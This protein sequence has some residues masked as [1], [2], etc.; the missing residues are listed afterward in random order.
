M[1]TFAQ[2]MRRDSA[3]LAKSQPIDPLAK[4]PAGAS[5][6]DYAYVPD[7][8]SPSTWKLNISDAGHVGGAIA[9]L[10]PGFRGRK[11]QIPA[12]ARARVVGRVR[13]AW[14]RF[15]PG[16]TP[17]TILKAEVAK[18][19][20]QSDPHL[21][22][23][24][25]PR[26]GKQKM[27]EAKRIGAQMGVDGVDDWQARDTARNLVQRGHIKPEHHKAMLAAFGRNKIDLNKAM[28]FSQSLA[29]YNHNHGRNGEFAS[30]AGGAGAPPVKGP[31]G[32]Q[33][34]TPSERDKLKEKGLWRDHAT[35]HSRLKNAIKQKHLIGADVATN[36]RRLAEAKDHLNT[37]AK[38]RGTEY[39]SRALNGA[40]AKIDAVNTHIARGRAW[41]GSGK[42][43]DER[44]RLNSGLSK[45]FAA[46]L[47][48]AELEAGHLGPALTAVS[49]HFR[50]ALA[51]AKASGSSAWN[52]GDGEVYDGG[53][54]EGDGPES[55]TPAA[56][57]LG[58]RAPGAKK[59]KVAKGERSDYEIEFSF[60]VKKADAAQQM[61]YGWANVSKLDGVEVTDREGDF[62]S[63]DELRKAAHDFI[64]K[65]REGDERHGPEVTGYIVE[66]IIVDDDIKKALGMDVP[67]E[68]WFIGYK[69]TND[70]VWKR[71]E[72]GEYKAFSI[73]GT[74]VRVPEAVTA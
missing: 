36:Q 61:I 68:G 34:Q 57:E 39:H 6:D 50:D 38:M 54:G 16:E 17:P 28:T 66:S 64:L 73:G 49:V 40:R 23:R 48:K 10:G 71:V 19:D 31:W 32:A 2:A 11:A 44:A 55:L 72:K 12:A 74:A 56:E 13:A 25:M 46:A 15:H 4:A 24:Y 8:K 52:D 69:V 5:A 42:P 41:R 37:A 67:Q 51:K 26:Q 53:L 43:F 63:I 59:K 7:P 9:A 22:D 62:A 35:A 21:A 33:H 45:H 20:P 3:A 65:S 60:E 1:L 18:Y 58:A 27:A 70:A 47:A 14:K 29:K 30:G